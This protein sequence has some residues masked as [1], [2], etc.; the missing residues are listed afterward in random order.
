MYCIIFVNPLSI[1]QLT[2]FVCVLNKDRVIQGSGLDGP[3]PSGIA[4]LTKMTDLLVILLIKYDFRR[5]SLTSPSLV[6][7]IKL[8]V[9]DKTGDEGPFPPLSNMTKLKTLLVNVFV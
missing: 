2:R 4:F 3:I 9:H 1:Y 8:I 5:N 7:I 6:L